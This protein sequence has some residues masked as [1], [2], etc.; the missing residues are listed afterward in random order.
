MAFKYKKRLK[1][2]WHLVSVTYFY[3]VL[4]KSK[5]YKENCK[6]TVGS[7]KGCLPM[8]CH[9]PYMAFCQTF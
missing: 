8:H 4:W 7:I 3:S 5:L 2:K 1:R 6:L 9:K